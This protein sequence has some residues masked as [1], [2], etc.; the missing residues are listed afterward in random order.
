MDKMTKIKTLDA[1]RHKG[2]LAALADLLQA[3]Y[4]DTDGHDRCPFC[5][6]DATFNG[7]RLR[8][9]QIGHDW[10]CR[11]LEARENVAAARKAMASGKDWHCAKCGQPMQFKD[12]MCWSCAGGDPG[13]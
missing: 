6:S 9:S 3:A 10:P 13:E 1:E 12:G 7:I 5:L 2:T 11:W 8:L 4:P